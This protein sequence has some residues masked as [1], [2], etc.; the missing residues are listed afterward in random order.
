[1]NDKVNEVVAALNGAKTAEGLAIQAEVVDSDDGL[2]KAELSEREEFPIMIE[3]DDDQITAIANLWDQTDV[4]TGMEAEMMNVML[5][6]NIALPL[7]AFAKTGRTY[8]LFGAM[9]VNTVMANVVEEITALSDNTIAVFD[10][11]G[12]YLNQ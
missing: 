10:A 6:M 5:S 8:Q 9:S 7:S 2:V 1:M 4:K 12:E 3:I 11:L